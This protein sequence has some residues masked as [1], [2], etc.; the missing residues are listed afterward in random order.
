VPE[1]EILSPQSRW[2]A[3]FAE[4]GARLRGSLGPLALSI[5][6]IG[7]TSVPGLDAKDVID[8]QISVASL[9]PVGPLEAAIEAAGYRLRDGAWSDHVP[10]GDDP[11]PRQWA[12]RYGGAREGE[13]RTHIHIRVG[14]RRN[15]R[16]ALLFRD[17]LR[18]TPAAATTYG[19]IKRELAARHADD[20][21]AYYAVKDPVCDLIMAAAE[22]WALTSGWTLPISDA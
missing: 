14:G 8:I 3:E 11:D 12:K 6:H 17:Y 2:P 21:D 9:D 13:R 20:V 10:E 1:I 15:Q 5:N 7:S 22:S 19:L 18:A 16:Y 4:I